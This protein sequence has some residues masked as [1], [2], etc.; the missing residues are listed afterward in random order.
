MHHESAGEDAKRRRGNRAGMGERRM[1]TEDEGERITLGG[2]SD[3]LTHP[4]H[5]VKAATSEW[6]RSELLIEIY[7][8]LLPT[9]MYQ[10]D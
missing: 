1:S 5:P 4:A 10:K 2:W 8:L 9:Y 3:H 6:G 7:P